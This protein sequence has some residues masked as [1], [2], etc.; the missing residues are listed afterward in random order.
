VTVEGNRWFSESD[1]RDAVRATPGEPIDAHALDDAVRALNANP[2]RKVAVMAEAGQA[3]GTTNLTVKVQDRRPLAVSATVGN[4]GSAGTGENQVSIGGDWGNAFGRGDTLG[5]RYTTTT[6]RGMLQ[7]V[8][9]SYATRLSPNNEITGSAGYS[10]TSP[11]PGSVIGSAGRMGNVSGRYVRQM[12]ARRNRLSIGVDW[13]ESN[14]NLLFGGESI[15]SS[16]VTSTQVAADFSASLRTGIGSA[17]ASVGATFSPGGI[18][19]RNTDAAFEVQREGATAR[20]GLLRASLDHVLPLPKGLAWQARVSTQWTP[21]RL[22]SSEQMAFG[23]D[24]SIR[25]LPMFAVTRDNGAIVSTE[26]RLPALSAGSRLTPRWQDQLGTFLFV[27][28]GTG[29]DHASPLPRMEVVSAGPGLRY[30]FAGHGVL[31]MAYGRVLRQ[32]GLRAGQNGR[33]HV[34]LQ[35]SF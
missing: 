16:S 30:Q 1:Y 31:Q 2:F 11:R 9:T 19:A 35:A 20:Y 32:E 10:R 25:G 26:F 15:F 13:R 14:N 3:P 5:L 18:G 28:Y 27:D 23:G 17:T 4:T 33:L 7:Q 24:G 8:S 12:A 34:Q 22:L 29:R 6:E 21:D